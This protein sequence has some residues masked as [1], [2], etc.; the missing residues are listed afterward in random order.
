MMRVR[1]RADERCGSDKQND[2][3][4]LHIVVPPCQNQE[5]MLT[6]RLCNSF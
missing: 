6:E 1:L 5:S 3:I 4:A 2:E